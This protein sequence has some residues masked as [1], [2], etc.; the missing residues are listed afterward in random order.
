ME[1]SPDDLA[2][3]GESSEDDLH[4]SN[5]VPAHR[6]ARE[7]SPGHHRHVWLLQAGSSRQSSTGEVSIMQSRKAGGPSQHQA[8]NSVD[9][10]RSHKSSDD[11]V[12][13]DDIGAP[14]INV[15]KSQ[16]GSTV[17]PPR[18]PNPD[19]RRTALRVT[20]VD[21]RNE[22]QRELTKRRRT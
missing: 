4:G 12:G 14:A 17:E 6:G 9:A 20:A 22:V 11:Q 7:E 18:S 2:A 10:S 1:Q 19:S 16:S 8:I 5:R 3:S 21:G 13:S 15:S